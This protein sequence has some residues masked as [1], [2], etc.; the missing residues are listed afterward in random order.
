MARRLNAAGYRTSRKHGGEDN[1]RWR[2]GPKPFS[3]DTVREMLQNEFYLGLTKYKGVLHEGQHPALVSQA[4]F[5]ASQQARKERFTT[6]RLDRATGRVY[7]LS[8]LIRC[9]ECGHSMAGQAVPTKGGR[10]RYYR[11]TAWRKG[12]ECSQRMVRAGVVEEQVVGRLLRLRLPEAWARRVAMLVEGGPEVER[13][14]RQRRIVNSRAER[15]KRLFLRGD[16]GEREYERRRRGIEAEL[17]RLV[18]GEL[19]LGQ[20][21]GWLEDLSVVWEPAAPAQRR[22]LVHILV[23]SVH[24]RGEVVE[25]VEPRGPFV[26]LFGRLGG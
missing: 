1:P 21:E 2:G 7:L 26:E 19:D 14:E 22:L 23:R 12:D 9:A 17:G 15:L 5:D 8:G 13:L 20:V 6:R 11:D 10:V 3:G 24:V 25:R 18:P 16:I 4:L